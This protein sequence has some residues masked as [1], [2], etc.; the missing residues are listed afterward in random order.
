MGS[1]QKPATN[2]SRNRQREIDQIRKYRHKFPAAPH[3]CHVSYLTSGDGI[4]KGPGACQASPIAIR[5]PGFNDRPIGLVG[6]SAP[7]PYLLEAF[8]TKPPSAGH[9]CLMASEMI[10]PWTPLLPFF[11]PAHRLPHSRR[12]GSSGS[13]CWTDTA[14]LWCTGQEVPPIECG[15]VNAQIV[16]LWIGRSGT[17]PPSPVC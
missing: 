16:V 8:W 7:L 6:G 3:G 2:L 15:Y 12:S 17:V 5:Q 10:V 4:L 11:S 9:Q 13:L 14:L 1:G